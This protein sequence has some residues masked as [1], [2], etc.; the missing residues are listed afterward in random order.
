MDIQV[1]L[2]QKYIYNVTYKTQISC[3]IAEELKSETMPIGKFRGFLYQ[4][5]KIW[6]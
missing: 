1:K 2:T 4:A 6:Q 5:N 3:N